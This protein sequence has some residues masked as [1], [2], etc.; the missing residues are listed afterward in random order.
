MCVLCWQ[1]LTADHWTESY[2]GR[3]GSAVGKGDATA[4]D[5]R[6]Y[7]RRRARRRRTQVLNHILGAYGLR[8]DD[9]QSRSYVLSDRKGGTILIQNL[10]ELW[11]AAEQL[12]GR[13]LDPLAPP[14]IDAL[15]EAGRA[16]ES[17]R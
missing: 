13:C 15:Q 16:S 12:V 7:S 6:E 17:S 4:G 8:L 11:P 14:L 2:V 1:F 3:D 5:E 10:G 9:W